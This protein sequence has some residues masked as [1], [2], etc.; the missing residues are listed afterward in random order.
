MAG[1]WHRA[2]VHPLQLL[3]ERRLDNTLAPVAPPSDHPVY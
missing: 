2:A 1:G 3:P